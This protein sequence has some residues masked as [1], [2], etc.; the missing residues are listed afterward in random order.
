MPSPVLLGVLYDFP[1][2]DNGESFCAALQLGLAA[3]P[4]LDREVEFVTRHAAGLP[5]GSAHHVETAFAE[6]VEA[7]VLAVVG[8]SI[9]DNGLVVRDLADAARVPCINYTGG[10]RTRSEWMLHY[11]VGSLEEEPLVLLENLAARGLR[12]AALLHDASPVGR[13]YAEC[14]SAGAPSRGVDVL[15]SIP[16]PPLSEDASEQVARARRSE[17]QA[18]VYLGLGVAARATAVAV[19][20]ADWDVPVVANSALMF[21]YGRKDW[22]A[23]WDGWVYVDTVADDN[24]Q[25]AA[26]KE[27]APKVAAGPIGVA[28]YDI[29]QLL[30]HAL[31]NA[32]HLTG[33]GALDALENVK[34]LPAT[35]GHAG[36]TMG[37]GTYDHGALKGPFLVLREWRDGRTVMA[38]ARAL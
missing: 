1:Q 35:S 24:P 33:A 37:F 27:Q 12:S 15:A 3:A 9:S 34:R 14:F 30:G 38:A 25:R 18:L 19:E 8:P 13:R 10:E 7:G 32:Q 22:R 5:G 4:A 26:L 21:G 6:V 2:P 31:A 20:A 36:T 28:A 23:G 29:G 17:P 11:Q 16:V